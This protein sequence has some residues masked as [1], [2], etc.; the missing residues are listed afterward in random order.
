ML[1]FGERGKKITFLLKTVAFGMAI[2]F[3][4]CEGLYI[5]NFISGD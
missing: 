1:P 2:F 3:L 5:L 4:F